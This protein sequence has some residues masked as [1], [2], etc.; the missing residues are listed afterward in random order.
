MLYTKDLEEIELS[1]RNID[2]INMIKATVL[3]II[4]LYTIYNIFIY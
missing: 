4:G 2:S 3:T 1:F